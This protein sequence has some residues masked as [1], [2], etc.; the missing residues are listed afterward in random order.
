MEIIVEYLTIIRS[1]MKPLVGGE[2]DTSPIGQPYLGIG[3]Q[4]MPYALLVF[5]SHL[6][7]WDNRQCGVY[8]L[9]I[10]ERGV[11][12]HELLSHLERIA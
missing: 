12:I 3:D 6:S 11:P 4:M 7:L 8:V 5:L 9:K 10:Q 2:I 1:N